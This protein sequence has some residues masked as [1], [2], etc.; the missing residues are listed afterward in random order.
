[1]DGMEEFENL[2]LWVKDESYFKVEIC[3]FSTLPDLLNNKLFIEQPLSERNSSD[4]IIAI[5]YE[6]WDEKKNILF[7]LLK[8][9]FKKLFELILYIFKD[10]KIT[11]N[12]DLKLGKKNCYSLQSA[13]LNENTV[14]NFILYLTKIFNELILLQ[15]LIDYIQ[16]TFEGVVDSELLKKK[17]KE[18]EQLNQELERKNKIDTLTQLYN[19]NAIFEF[20][21]RF[22]YVSIMMIDIDDFKKINDDFGH[23]TGDGVLR[24]MGRLLHDNRL[25]RLYD[26]SGRFGG[27]EFIVLLPNTNVAD[28]YGPAKRLSD[29]LQKI[30]FRSE[31]NEPFHVTISIGLSQYHSSDM[32][33]EDIILRADK[34]LYYAKNHGKDMVVVYEEIFK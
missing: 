25:F 16:N 20:L 27:E 6:Y 8:K 28:A 32:R 24:M 22:E 10:N 11:F 34:A 13:E 4:F 26:K 3:N 9:H 29:E 33:A 21:K 12:D 2:F 30:E 7:D 31:N 5:N 14:T 23:L 18:I 1:M 15:R 19:R 17:Q